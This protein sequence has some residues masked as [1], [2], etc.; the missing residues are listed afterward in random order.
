MHSQWCSSCFWL[1]AK[2]PA[3]AELDRR[4]IEAAKRHLG[5]AAGTAGVP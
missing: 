4:I 5:A 2:I 1:Q 3:H